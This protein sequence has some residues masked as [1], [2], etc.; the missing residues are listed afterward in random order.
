MTSTP[1]TVMESSLTSFRTT[2]SNSK[3][4]KPT[5]VFLQLLVAKPNQ[6]CFEKGPL[7]LSVPF[8]LEFGASAY[9]RR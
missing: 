8:H 9:V 4:N 5:Q 6:P 1:A 3:L 7:K 2:G